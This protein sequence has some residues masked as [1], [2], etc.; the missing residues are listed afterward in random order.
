M[1]LF[2]AN[3][4]IQVEKG[5]H[6]LPR[7]DF[8]FIKALTTKGISV[9]VMNFTTQKD[10]P[11]YDYSLNDIGGISILGIGSHKGKGR[12][13]GLSKVWTYIKGVSRTFVYLIKDKSFVYVYFPGPIPMVA[14]LLCALLGKKYALYVRGVWKTEG[15]NNVVSNY[16]FKHAQFIFTTGLGFASTIKKQNTN[17]EPVYPMTTFDVNSVAKMEKFERKEIKNILFVGNLVKTKGVLDVVKAIDLLRKQGVLVNLKIIGG[18]DLEDITE[19]EDLIAELAVSSEVEYVG[20]ISDAEKLASYFQST[21]LFLYPSYYP[22]GFPRVV[23]EAMIFGIPII[24]TILPGMK[25]FM[26]DG[27]NCLE[28]PPESAQAISDAVVRLKNDSAL[29]KKIGNRSREMIKEYFDT[30]TVKGHENQFY[31]DFIKLKS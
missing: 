4:A 15:L 27:V 19:L 1:V 14:A 22:E 26:E 10:N 16:I 29:S 18:G 13:T 28:V 8:E 31:N 6:Y 9:S 30:F 11:T 12:L 3:T 2:V 5:K 17:V 7:P 21:D 20:H 24:C 23:F 25:S